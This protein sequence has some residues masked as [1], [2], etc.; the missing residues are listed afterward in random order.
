MEGVEL[1]LGCDLPVSPCA[2]TREI[3]CEF[4]QLL[5]AVPESYSGSGALPVKSNP[6]SMVLAS[7]NVEI[8]Q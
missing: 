4:T 1:G 3:G 6:V 5:N 7:N 2:S 8:S